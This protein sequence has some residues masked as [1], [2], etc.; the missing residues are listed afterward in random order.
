MAR[1]SLPRV[2]RAG[3]R[4]EAAVV[5]STTGLPA[6]DVELQAEATGL[7]LSGPARPVH[8]DAGVPVEAAL[9]AA[10]RPRRAR[11]G[12]TVHAGRASAERATT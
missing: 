10:R 9:P 2:I 4:F 3:D 8:A 11:R 6:G 5:V 7:T 12:S 1:A